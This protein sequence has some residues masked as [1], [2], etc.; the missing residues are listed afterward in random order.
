[1]EIKV[2]QNQV[3]IDKDILNDGEYKINK[4]EFEFDEVYNGLVKKAV[5]S[6]DENEPYKMT[7]TDNKC[8]I[9]IEVL[10]EGILKIGVYAYE[11]DNEELLLRY[12]PS[13][14]TI[15]IFDGSYVTNAQNSEPV[16]PTDKEQM[17]QMLQDGLDDI[18]EAVENA[19]KLDIDVSKTGKTTTVSITKQNGTTKSEDVLDGAG[20][21]YNWSGTY[22]GIKRDDE[23]NY[24]YVNLKGDT[25]EPGQIEFTIVN[26]L[27][28]EGTEGIIYLVSLEVPDTEENN[29]AEYIYVDNAWELLG[30][31]GVQVDLS[32]YYTKQEVNNLIPDELA[33]LADDSTHRLVTDTEKSIWN[34][35]YNKPSGGIPKTDLDS[36]VQTSLGKADTSLQEHQ[37]ISGKEDK[38]NKVT[39]LSSSSTD[40]QYPSAKTVYDS[41]QTQDENIT[42]NASNIN[43]LNSL[44]DQ[45][46]RVSGTGTD[47]SLEDVLD[48]RLMKFV[49]E[50]NS[51]QDGTPTH[52]SSIPVKVVTGEN[53]LV[54]NNKN[55]EDFNTISYQANANATITRNNGD[56]TVQGSTQSYAGCQFK[57]SDLK[58]QP[59]TTYTFSAKIK[60]TTNT[61]GSLVYISA[62]MSNTGSQKW[63]TQVSAGNISYATF[64]TPST[65]NSNAFIGLYT[66][67][68]SNT[69]V[70]NDIQLEKGSIATSYIA[71]EEQNYDI[72][73]KSNNIIGLGTTQCPVNL[74]VGDKV[75]LKNES[76]SN[77]QFQLFT[78]YGDETRND[79][80]SVDP[81]NSRTITVAHNSKAVSWNK[82][83]ERGIA[84]ANL[85][86]T[87]LAYHPYTEN[88]IELASTPD[89]TIRDQI[90]GTPDNWYKREYIGKV[91][92]DGSE[93]WDYAN[94]VFNLSTTAR[95]LLSNWLCNALTFGG[96][97]IN[98]STAYQN[99]NNKIS[100][101]TSGS[102]IYIRIDDIT[103]VSDFKTYLSNFFCE[104]VINL[105]NFLIH[106]FFI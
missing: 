71:H 81:N 56:I 99:G 48:Y 94:G 89:G 6:W 11:V 106:P 53:S 52:S 64:T 43:E 90:I 95:Y 41:Q 40:T 7:I 8:D 61:S 31:I 51:S 45:L 67:G 22:L 15:R 12:S 75:T 47:L 1:M 92:L 35:K 102:R 91:V 100:I 77:L 42:E 54:I 38:A 18:A 78:N 84:W 97:A 20:L 65:I 98:T 69:A 66:G 85:G 34:G 72:T 87:L 46:P 74:K 55:L 23:Q 73:L 44:V 10:Q 96:T 70:F 29:Y 9:P 50:G 76:S 93:D 19:E 36:S 103:S 5:F 60:S 57:Q 82:N 17:E 68:T 25:G 2:T 14:D 88:P 59:N 63:G 86:E 104:F 21:E 105:P 4:C 13:P 79:F 27:P 26:E 32:N 49:P 58:L 33:D 3:K 62:D 101:N 37:D 39:S 24:E 30:K 83:I 28:Q 16:T 80:W